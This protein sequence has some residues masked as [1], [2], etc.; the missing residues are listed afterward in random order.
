MLIMTTAVA[1]MEGKADLARK[2][3]DALSQWSEYLI[4]CGMDPK[5]QLSTDDFAGHLARNANLFHQGNHG[6]S[7]LW[8]PG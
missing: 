8:D 3:L 1:E 5:N 6:H 7:R 2:H 4:E